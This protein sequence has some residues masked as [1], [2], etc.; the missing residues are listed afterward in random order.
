MREEDSNHEPTVFTARNDGLVNSHNPVQLSAWRGNVD[1]QY[2]ASKYK[3][4]EYTSSPCITI[5]IT[6][7]N[8]LLE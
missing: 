6:Y 2:C 7:I 4:I 3:V 5:I 1:M 8:A